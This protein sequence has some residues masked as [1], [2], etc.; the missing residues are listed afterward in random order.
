MCVHAVVP[1]LWGSVWI[2]ALCI[3]YTLT[4][5]T[6]GTPVWEKKGKGLDIAVQWGLWVF[7]VYFI[8]WRGKNGV[9]W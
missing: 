5:A 9:A 4:S 7:A 3:F 6:P 8:S 1:V 2:S